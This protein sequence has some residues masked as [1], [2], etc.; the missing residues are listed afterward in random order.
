MA[1]MR[2]WRGGGGGARYGGVVPDWMIPIP[3]LQLSL[4]NRNSVV[5]QFKAPNSNSNFEPKRG[6]IVA[7]P[8]NGMQAPGISAANLCKSKAS[9]RILLYILISLPSFHH[10]LLCVLP[11][12]VASML[13][14]RGA[15]V[16]LRVRTL[17]PAPLSRPLTIARPA[18]PQPGPPHDRRHLQ[19]AR[20]LQ[21][22]PAPVVTI[23][24]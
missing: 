13:C 3:P 4:P 2:F 7:A 24:H 22:A 21:G 9:P 6:C 20:R 1:G 19:Q 15:G 14:C 5:N 17:P 23:S 11:P 16:D 8:P 12:P 18:G 10:L